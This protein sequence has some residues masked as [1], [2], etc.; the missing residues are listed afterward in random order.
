[1]VDQS[2]PKTVT[3]DESTA[4]LELLLQFMHITEDQPELDCCDADM[5]VRLAE[6]VEK[7][8]VRVAQLAVKSAL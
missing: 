8:Q 5:V 4:V 1:V 3:L 7:Y 6:A 2:N